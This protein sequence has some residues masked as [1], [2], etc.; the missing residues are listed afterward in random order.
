MDVKKLADVH[1]R[2]EGLPM[3]GCLLNFPTTSDSSAVSDR[4][5]AC[6]R[7]LGGGARGGAADCERPFPAV[8]PWSP[9]PSSPKTTRFCLLQS[10]R[11]SVRPGTSRRPYGGVVVGSRRTAVS[12]QN[13]QAPAA[14]SRHDGG[15]VQHLSR[16]T[17][18][19]QRP[20]PTRSAI[21]RNYPTNSNALPK[22]YASSRAADAA[23]SE[24]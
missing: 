11:G 20:G 18:Q 6:R 22:K 16:E 9:V 10:R 19:P 4:S 3:W 17:G 2:I 14:A 7:T 21:R 8:S 13:A 15:L 5:T 12:L 23:L 1:G 24:P